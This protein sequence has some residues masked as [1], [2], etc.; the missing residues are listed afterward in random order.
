MFIDFTEN[1]NP[2]SLSPQTEFEEKV[3]SFLKEWYS[4]VPKVSVQ[5]SGSTGIPKVFEIEKERMCHSAN[6]TCDILNLKE[7]DSALL[8]L[9]LP[10]IHGW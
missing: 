7:G 1:I 9:P 8:C 2:E 6:K 10:H 5:T 3:I 4:S